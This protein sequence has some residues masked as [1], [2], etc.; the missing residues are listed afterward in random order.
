MLKTRGGRSQS[1]PKLNLNQHKL[2]SLYLAIN[3]FNSY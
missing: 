1:K 2:F 3:N